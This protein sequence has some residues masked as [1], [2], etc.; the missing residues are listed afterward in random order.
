MSHPTEPAQCNRA[1]RTL[2]CTLYRAVYELVNLRGGEFIDDNASQPEDNASQPEDLAL[3]ILEG[4]GP[5][6][7]EGDAL[8][9]II[10]NPRGLTD[11]LP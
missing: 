5:R 7:F 8:A 6:V 3:I 9:S 10:S 11:L 2:L 4:E 1:L